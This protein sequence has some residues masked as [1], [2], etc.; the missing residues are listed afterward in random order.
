MPQHAATVAPA[1]SASLTTAANVPAERRRT[2]A[3]AST[4]LY[5]SI[6]LAFVALGS[7]GVATLLS[8]SS[9]SLSPSAQYAMAVL[10]ALSAAALSGFIIKGL[11]EIKVGGQALLDAI[12][13]INIAKRAA[14]EAELGSGIRALRLAQTGQV[15]SGLAI[16]AS[17]AMLVT[18]SLRIQTGNVNLLAQE[19]LMT[20]ALLTSGSNLVGFLLLTL[21]GARNADIQEKKHELDLEVKDA[22]MTEFQNKKRGEIDTLNSNHAIKLASKAGENNTLNAHLTV[23][24]A[25]LRA[26]G[27]EPPPMSPQGEL[28]SV[29]ATAAGAGLFQRR[30]STVPRSAEVEAG[31]VQSSNTVADAVADG[32]NPTLSVGR[33]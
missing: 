18:T 5:L 24:E 32:S 25:Q 8:L 31:V 6:L 15:C 33:Q 19:W 20:Y 14:T 13:L 28:S 16:G 7:G 23:L 4:S 9:S 11:G 21:L 26:A 30:H 29:E 22:R 27:I 12:G 17:G 1:D 3:S 10:A 2:L